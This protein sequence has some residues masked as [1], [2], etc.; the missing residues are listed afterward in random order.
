MWR[1]WRFFLCDV[2]ALVFAWMIA[3]V[4]M[5]DDAVVLLILD[6]S[7]GAKQLPPSGNSSARSVA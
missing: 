2:L 4:E 7:G 5:D 3:P 6:T 1:L